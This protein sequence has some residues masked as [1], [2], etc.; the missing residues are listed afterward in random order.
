MLE[1]A[2][3][4]G[5]TLGSGGTVDDFAAGVQDSTN[6]LNNLANDLIYGEGGWA[7]QAGTNTGELIPAVLQY[8]LDQLQKAG[9]DPMMK[10]QLDQFAL[11][12]EA[13][14]SQIQ[15]VAGRMGDPA[16]QAAMIAQG[17]M[18]ILDRFGKLM[19]QQASAARDYALQLIGAATGAGGL[20]LGGMQLNEQSRQFYANLTVE[21]RQFF[22]SLTQDQQQFIATL[23][24]NKQQFLMTY[25]L[26]SQ[27]AKDAM[28]RWQ[29]ELQW[30]KD[31]T[32][33]MNALDWQKFSAQFNLSKQEFG[34]KLQQFAQDQAN[35]SSTFEF[36]KDK[37]TKT[38]GLSQ[39][40]LEANLGIRLEELALNRMQVESQIEEMDWENLRGDI[41]VL[42]AVEDVDGAGALLAQLVGRNLY[43]A[44]TP[45]YQDFVTNATQ[46]YVVGLSGGTF[47]YLANLMG[48]GAPPAT[49]ELMGRTYNINSV[50]KPADGNYDLLVN[51]QKIGTWDQALGRFVVDD[52][53]PIVKEIGLQDDD[54]IPPE[55]D[56]GGATQ[57]NVQEI[58]DGDYS[59]LEGLSRTSQ[60]YLDIVASLP[61]SSS[62]PNGQGTAGQVF[63]HD[64]Q[65][66]KV[67]RAGKS[68]MALQNL[69]VGGAYHWDYNNQT[70]YT[71]VQGYV[72]YG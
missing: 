41:E 37:F 15:A 11:A 71:P 24:Q 49:I 35:W 5:Q 68:G 64:G 27:E 52:T 18:N 44:D 58:L 13:T 53:N 21:D 31:K 9:S 72:Y 6:R 26:Q 30:D 48:N 25:G 36:D 57:T 28:T 50:G 4:R 55:G 22:S 19:A 43:G 1:Q 62:L 59:S 56:G 61:K 3:R 2:E 14:R 10:Q 7:A 66:Y 20:E 17:E 34:L 63:V 8:V 12:A 47:A 16:A 51:G 67:T 38:F 54:L 39:Q 46:G 69:S 42:M 45:E 33:Q 29:A 70:G 40:E 23:D 32:A 65:I 60:E